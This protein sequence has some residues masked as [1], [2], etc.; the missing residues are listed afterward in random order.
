VVHLSGRFFNRDSFF[1]ALNTLHELFGVL[2]LRGHN[3]RHT[4]VSEH[5]GGNAEQVVH[6]AADKGLVVADS[7]TESVVLHEKN[8]GDIQ[9]PS[10]VLGAEFSRL[11]EDFLNGGIV[12]FIPVELGLH[13]EDGDVLVE[14]GIVFL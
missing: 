9:L 13:H 7:V 3:I 10:F 12:L 1:F 4:Q 14:T 11:F 2:I 8:M 5:D 6:L